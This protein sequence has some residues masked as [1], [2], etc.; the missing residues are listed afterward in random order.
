MSAVSWRNAIMQCIYGFIWLAENTGVK[1]SI[2][3]VYNKYGSYNVGS[4]TENSAA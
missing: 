2:Q 1:E 3:C 4:Y